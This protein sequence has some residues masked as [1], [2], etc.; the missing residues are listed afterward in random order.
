MD[1]TF[2]AREM[3]EVR[4]NREQR[5]TGCGRNSDLGTRAGAETEAG[6]GARA[7]D[8]HGYASARGKGAAKVR[9]VGEVVR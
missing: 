3:E 5:F 9:A 7:C 6:A 2:M 4:P 1:K 8:A